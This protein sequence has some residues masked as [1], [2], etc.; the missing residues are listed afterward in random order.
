MITQSLISFLASILVYLVNILPESTG[1]SGTVSSSVLTLINTA[2]S[3]DYYFPISAGFTAL[4]IYFVFQFSIWLW[5]MV[6]YFIGF[7]R[8]VRG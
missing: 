2:L 8:G 6:R 5:D 7:L 4:S 3:W 1:L